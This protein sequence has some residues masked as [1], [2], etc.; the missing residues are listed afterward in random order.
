MRASVVA[1]TAKTIIKAVGDL[2]QV[3]NSQASPVAIAATFD[4]FAQVAVEQIAIVA[5]DTAPS[6]ANNLNAAADATVTA[7]KVK[8]NN[9]KNGMA[10]GQQPGGNGSSSTPIDPPLVDPVDTPPLVDPVVTPP[11]VSPNVVT[12]P[13]V[14]HNVGNPTAAGQTTG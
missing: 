6:Y 11:V 13:V 7:V 12:P 8:I 14:S 10:G 9:A 2:P 4:K 5:P 1:E 3:I